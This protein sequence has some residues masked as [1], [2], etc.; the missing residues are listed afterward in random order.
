MEAL[1]HLLG[2]KDVAPVVV[3]VFAFIL[4]IV[5]AIV[6]LAT[7]YF[8]VYKRPHLN[9]LTGSN[10][11]L[12]Y[13]SGHKVA[14][15]LDLVI[16][17]EG[18]RAGSIV[19]LSGTISREGDDGHESSQSAA[20]EWDLF[21]VNTNIARPGKPSRPSLYTEGRVVPLHV[22]P[23]AAIARQIR[24]CTKV[25]LRLRDGGYRVELVGAAH[26]RRR[27]APRIVRTL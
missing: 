6:S 25:P 18:A 21:M 26:P 23:H 1:V 22:P 13:R 9:L 10:S 11:L 27:K 2:G 24:F 14:F 3:S 12:G 7:F 8:G 4:S 16:F 15:D 17:N 5:S 19:E 20:F